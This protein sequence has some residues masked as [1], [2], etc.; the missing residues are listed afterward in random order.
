MLPALFAWVAGLGT[1]NIPLIV[2][3]IACVC[4]L[5]AGIAAWSAP[6]TSRIP[7]ADLGKRDARPTQANE[8]H[9]ARLTA[10]RASNH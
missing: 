1:E 3:S 5:L 6:E 7:M 4:A 2:G 8:Y 10:I 9:Q